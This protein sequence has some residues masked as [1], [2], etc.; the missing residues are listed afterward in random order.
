MNKQNKTPIKALITYEVREFSDES[1]TYSTDGYYDEFYNNDSV[2]DAETYD[3]PYDLP[4]SQNEFVEALER[5]TDF[6]PDEINQDEIREGF[7]MLQFD[8]VT[9]EFEEMA[10][11]GARDPD[12]DAG[13]STSVPQKIII[14]FDDG[15][16]DEIEI[17]DQE[18]T[19]NR[20]LGI[21]E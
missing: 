10:E 14:Y 5:W 18:D 1:S 20:I 9:D 11:F 4:K 7:G 8:D 12:D 16:D 17:T 2:D 19:L 6:V 15:T 3:V 21:I 13:M